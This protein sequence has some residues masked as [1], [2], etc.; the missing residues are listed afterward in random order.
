MSEDKVKKVPLFVEVIGEPSTGK[1]HLSSL[2]PNPVLLDTTSKGEGYSVIKK[3]F[4][5]AWERRY[6]RVKCFEDFRKHLKYIKTKTD[7]YKTVIVD[8]S[9]DLRALG[10]KEYLGELNKAGKDR[11]ALMPQ[12]WRW[13]NEKVN[14][15]IRDITDPD[16]LCMNLVFTSQMTDEWISGKPTGRRVR[17]GVPDM[18]FQADIR[19]FLQLR[20]KVDNTMRYTGEF[21]RTCSV[22]KCRFR[23][24]A[25]SNDWINELKNISWEGIKE[26]SKLRSE[27]IVE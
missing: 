16:K 26:L 20:Q 14:D 18:N 5:D 7:F 13:V 8:T 10:S 6:F 1:T 27:E 24:Q 3:L 23:D 25:D 11:Q 9:P 2:F 15:W 19:L 4:P 12:E 21:E 22:L 17:K